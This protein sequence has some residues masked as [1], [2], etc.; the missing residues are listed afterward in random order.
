MLDHG[1]ARVGRP[2]DG[3]DI[4]TQR[5][6]PADDGGEETPERLASDAV[7]CASRPLRPGAR[8]ESDWRV[9]TSTNTTTRRSTATRSS[10]PHRVARLAGH[11]PV[12]LAAQ[13]SAR[14]PLRR[15]PTSRWQAG[16]PAPEASPHR[17]LSRPPAVACQ[18][19]GAAF[20]QADRLADTTAEEEQ[21][22][23]PHDARPFHFDLG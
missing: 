8:R 13:D 16:E 20:G 15:V 18:G 2:E 14:P 6:G 22:R 12:A 3:H 21:L 19:S 17:A 10:S 4:E 9:L 23:A 7:A 5:S 1:A 11:D